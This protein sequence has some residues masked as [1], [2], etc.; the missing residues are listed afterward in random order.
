MIRVHCLQHVDFEGPANI[1]LWVKRNGHVMSRTL[2]FAGE[3]FPSIRDFD[4]LV[5]MGGPMSVGDEK[6]YPWLRTE[7]AF[8]SE[9]IDHGKLVFG[10]CL[11]AQL[12]ANVLGARVFKNA[13]KEIGWYPVFLTKDGKE[14]LVFK[15][16]PDEFTAFHWHGDT[17][18]LPAGAKGLVKSEGCANQAF[19]YNGHV[20]GFQFHLES[21]EESI[22]E[23]VSHCGAEL[24]KGK[25]VQTKPFM[26]AQK[27]YLCEIERLVF[28][29]LDQMVRI[30]IAANAQKKPMVVRGVFEKRPFGHL[31]DVKKE[32]LI[33]HAERLKN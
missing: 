18:D 27:E 7:K 3:F 6:E 22:H 24:G 29:L 32:F 8:I 23:L 12:I 2:V 1:E 9:A 4:W 17:F 28:C 33:K 19:E 10:I 14:S 26:L 15:T 25:F 31:N 21:T 30:K 16:L 5:I 11:G 13:H 20:F